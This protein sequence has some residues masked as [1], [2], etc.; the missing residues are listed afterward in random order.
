MSAADIR[1]LVERCYDPE[2]MQRVIA[3]RGNPLDGLNPNVPPSTGSGGPITP[4]PLPGDVI[5]NLV[6]RCYS[7]P[8][9]NKPNPKDQE[10]PPRTPEEPEPPP[11]DPPGEI[12][13]TLVGRCYGPPPPPF[14]PDPPDDPIRDI[15]RIDMPPWVPWIVEITGIDP[16]PMII[17][18]KPP[19]KGSSIVIITGSGDPNDCDLVAEFLKEDMVKALPDYS[20]DGKG[21]PGW[22]EHKETKKKYFCDLSKRIDDPFQPC[23][24]NALECLFRPYFGGMWKPPKTDCDAYWPNGWSGN[25]DEVCVKNCFPDR[26]PIYE[27]LDSTGT[28]NVTFNSTGQLVATGSGSV[29]VILKLWWND[30]PWTHGTAIDSIEVAGKTFTRVGRSGEQT[31]T[32]T[33][34]SAGT[35][36]VIFTGLHSANSTLNILDDNTRICMLDGHGSD[37]NA[38]FTIVS[39]NA[40]ADHAYYQT[41]AKAGYTL[42]NTEPGFYIL[43]D[44]IPGKT[45][46]LF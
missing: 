26:I 11:V 2:A 42:T 18:L 7:D 1:L 45:V 46:P 40:S 3:H 31:E 5:R 4:P 24:K 37:C 14:I 29:E 21:P 19:E 35:I 27:S 28:I 36:P 33:V 32:I 30:R 17:T 12:I 15:T 23:V 16:P 41:G 39:T 9:P 10:F 34:S 43:R 22:W 8:V 38:N 13:R 6:G 44:P 20:Q 25:Q